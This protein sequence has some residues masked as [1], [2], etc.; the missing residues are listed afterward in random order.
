MRRKY[1]LFT[2]LFS[3][4]GMSYGQQQA[5]FAQYMFN[6]LAINPA[7]A[8][9]QEALSLNVLSRF[10]NVGLPGAPTTQT[11]GIHTPLLNQR[12]ALGLLVMHDNIS[13][14]N[15]T[16]VSGIYAYRIPLGKGKLSMGIQ[17]GFSSYQAAY[18][19]LVTYQQD[20]VFS[21]D[22]RQT[23]PNFGMGL[24]YS[25]KLWYAG[26]SLPHMMSDIFQRGA[27]FET[28]HQSVPLI[29]TGGYVFTLNRM[30]KIKPNFMFK[31]V[32]SRIVEFDL[33]ANLLLDEVLWLG[34][35][36]N[37]SHAVTGLI[38]MQATD[39]FRLGYSYTVAMGPIQSAELGSHE[40]LLSYRFKNFSKG[41]VTP[42]YF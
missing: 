40:I 23:R 18:S 25:T 20:L 28:I 21:Q 41:I 30:M 15:Q 10:Q 36:Y 39:K 3:L 32:D 12:V 24:Y 35:S 2:L 26:I 1:L 11:L 37:F 14:I 38:E 31:T 6:G 9:S 5:M 27:N 33:N 7:Y 16:G 22:V 42:R 29:L 4:A 19:K 13:V 8:G 17:A 34:V